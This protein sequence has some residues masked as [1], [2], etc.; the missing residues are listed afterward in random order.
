VP[1]SYTVREGLSA[2]KRAKFAAL[3]ATSALTVSL[4]LIALFALITWQGA[5]VID[6]LRQRVGEVEVFLSDAA[7]ER[8]TEALR[9]RLL[10][11][12]GID[13]VEYV[14][15]AEATE[16]YR[17]AFGEEAALLPEN[18]FLPASFRVQVSPRYAYPDSLD[19]LAARLAELNRVDE[20]IFNQPLMAKVQRNLSLFTPLA[21]GIGFIVVLAALFL[22]GNTIRLTVYARRMLIR[23]MKLVGATNSFIRRPF[24]VEGVVQGAAAGVVACLLV[25]PVYGLIL[26]TIP[27]LRQQGWPGGTPIVTLV[28]ILLLG[29]LLGWLGS[30]IA[31]RRFIRSVRIE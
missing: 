14:S 1:L 28:G 29:I 7:D 3:T 5:Q 13:R 26:D 19:R 4:V 8:Q 2:F 27:Q 17:R 6:W 21:L 11:T 25:G 24:L 18:A 20:V 31:V 23:T 30:W 10:A 9:L 16:A 12:P 22:V 15:R